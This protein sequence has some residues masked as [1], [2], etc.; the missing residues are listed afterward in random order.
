LT[1]ARASPP[2]I[3]VIDLTYLH[4]AVAPLCL[5]L[6]LML[7]GCARAGVLDTIVFG[8]I[9]MAE[10]Q[11]FDPLPTWFGRPSRAAMA[12]HDVAALLWALDASGFDDPPPFGVHL[13]SG[14]F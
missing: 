3:V 14:D 1:Y 13:D 5:S 12:T 11:R 2:L 6:A 7:A 8:G 10:I 4:G 9:E